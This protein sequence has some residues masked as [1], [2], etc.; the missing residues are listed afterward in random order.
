MLLEH[1]RHAKSS[2]TKPVDNSHILS[3][4][5]SSDAGIATR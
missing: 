2:V 3:Y 4:Q 5:E 1:G